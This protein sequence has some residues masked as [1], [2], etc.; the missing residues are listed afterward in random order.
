MGTE[1]GRLP[2]LRVVGI[3][4]NIQQSLTRPAEP[5]VF[6]PMAHDWIFNYVVLARSP[7]DVLAAAA[8]ADAIFRRAD[9]DIPVQNM[10]TFAGRLG[11]SIAQPRLNAALMSA[12]A[13]IALLT[14]GIGVYGVLAYSVA[15]RRK[16]LGIRV[17]IGATRA[18]VLGAVL[19]DVAK[20]AQVALVI[21]IGGALIATRLLEGMLFGVQPMDT[22]TLGV[23]A[24]SMLFVALVAALL[25]AR[26]A[27][28]VD[29]VNALRDE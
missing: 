12:F 6:V 27:V 18:Q 15:A 10:G 5:E 3:V 14:A 21:G 13:G 1:D 26:A 17:A 24:V 4:D 23:A 11:S 25:P 9:S 16:E 7:G 19:R 8:E 28:A 22:A 20:L 2:W 29:P